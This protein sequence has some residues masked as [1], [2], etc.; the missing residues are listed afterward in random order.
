MISGLVLGKISGRASAI[1][2]Y[3]KLISL[4]T[5]F[6]GVRQNTCCLKVKHRVKR[7]EKKQE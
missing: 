6:A 2:T 7:S 4:P 5:F 1:N 3:T